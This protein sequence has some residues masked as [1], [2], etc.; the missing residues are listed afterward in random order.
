[1]HVGKYFVRKYSK[2]PASNVIG[3]FA[4]YSTHCALAVTCGRHVK[5]PRGQ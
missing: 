4:V 1:M 5:K 3:H 2:Y